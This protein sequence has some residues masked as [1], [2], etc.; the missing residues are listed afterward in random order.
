MPRRLLIAGTAVLALAC[1]KAAV[2]VDGDAGTAPPNA[3]TA[4]PAP[5][6]TAPT[7]PLPG[8]MVE[9]GGT[10]RR[11]KYRVVVRFV[12]PKVGE[13]FAVQAEALPM[14]ATDTGGVALTLDASM[15]A[16]R[17]GMMTDPKVTPQSPGKWRVEGMKLH[18]HGH[19]VLHATLTDSGLQD[20][21]DLPFEQPP[22]AV[23]P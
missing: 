21:I 4:S 1:T 6:V 17:H 12:V 2:P 8:T 19:W 11:G 20:E 23:G 10:T 9:L 18:M 16:H 3:A 7:A 13:L 5:T 15:P 14:A 22:E